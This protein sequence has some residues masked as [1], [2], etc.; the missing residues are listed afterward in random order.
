VTAPTLLTVGGRDQA[1]LNLNRRA[2]A[3]LH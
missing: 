2:Q 1:E 3:E